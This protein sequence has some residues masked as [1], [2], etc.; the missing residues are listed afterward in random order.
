MEERAHLKSCVSS[1]CSSL[2]A[3]GVAICISERHNELSF[4][5]CYCCAPAGACDTAVP[6]RWGPRGDCDPAGG[7]CYVLTITCARSS[8]SKAAE[9]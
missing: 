7:A 4:P 5:S 3:A 9:Q 1:S 8:S 2:S 6:G